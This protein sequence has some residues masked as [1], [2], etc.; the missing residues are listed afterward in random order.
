MKAVVIPNPGD[1]DVLVVEEVP[2]P[3]P[4]RGEVL[5]R[6][7]AA[8]LNRA[9]LLQRMGF[10]AAPPGV[11]PRIPGL[12]YAGIVE[13]TG[14]GTSLRKVGDRVMGILGGAGYAELVVV[15]ERETIRVP[16][17]MNLV[18][19]AGVPEVFVTAYDALWV[20][21]GLQPGM[22]CLIRPATSGVGIAACQLARALGARS[23]GTSRS[24]ERLEAMRRWGLDEG[25]VDA[26]PD[27]PDAVKRITGGAGVAAVLDMLGA[28]C[29]EAHLQ[30]LALRGTVVV[31]G[32][33]AGSHDSIHLGMLLARRARVVGT[34]LRS[35]P[36]EEKIQCARIFEER[37]L[38][39]F[40]RGALKPFVDIAL[41]LDQ[42]AE[43]HRRMEN[44][45]HLG[46]IVLK[47]S[48]FE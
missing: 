47:V 39:L 29:T 5:V 35:R 15:H 11:E 45:Q 24:A 16:D 10:Y 3:K 31:I 26:G 7:A 13:Q 14:P 2:D 17:G 33:M 8:G 41:P 28:G 42:A 36:L 25:L 21:A 18:D 27:L 1:P 48:N 34:V 40:A 6:V 12:E 30:C 32:L 22:W 9:D 19:A 37:L 20:Q 46:K 4:S 43:A 44:G 23:I 38:P